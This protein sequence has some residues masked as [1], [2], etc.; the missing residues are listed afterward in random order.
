M[1]NPTLVIVEVL[2]SYSLISAGLAISVLCCS[3]FLAVTA[4]I[5]SL[6]PATSTLPQTTT[7]S[8]L[9]QKSAAAQTPSIDKAKAILLAEGSKELQTTRSNYDA[10]YYS[11]FETWSSDVHQGCKATALQTVDVVF[12]LGRDGEFFG[13]ATVAE[14][15]SLSVVI[16][17]DVNYTSGPAINGSELAGYEFYDQAST[18]Q[19]R[20][21]YEAMVSFSQPEVNQPYS[22]A[23]NYNACT[24]GTWA[25]LEDMIGGSPA[26]LAQSDGGS[27]GCLYAS[28]IATYYMWY[29]LSPSEPVYCT[30]ATDPSVWGTR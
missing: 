10:T 18:G 14:T 27:V 23:C 11:T 15:P 7:C 8:S 24:L 26:G 2:G 25:G 16:G 4:S 19:N 30:F 13:Y 9:I 22:R 20:P 6:S 3:A 29:Q 1:E 12:A 28:C 5:P 21:L 17:V